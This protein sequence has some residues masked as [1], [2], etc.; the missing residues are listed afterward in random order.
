MT[1]NYDRDEYLRRQ[2][3]LNE[4]ITWKAL[5]DI[6]KTRNI[7]RESTATVSEF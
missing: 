4:N 3:M 1:H 7:A 5:S 6:L 2:L